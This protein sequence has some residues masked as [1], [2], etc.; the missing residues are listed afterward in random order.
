[1]VGGAGHG[2]L[3]AADIFR[4]LYR[5]Y[6]LSGQWLLPG[7]RHAEGDG[8]AAQLPA[9]EFRPQLLCDDVSGS[10]WIFRGHR[11]GGITRSP[12][13]S[14]FARILART[15]ESLLRKR[16]RHIGARTLGL[17]YAGG[18]CPRAVFECDFPSWTGRDWPSH[19]RAVLVTV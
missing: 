7:I 19:V 11:R 12:E 6:F 18:C 14:R 10:R 3:M 16:D 4:G 15:S 5:L 17:D 2:N 9:S 13:W 8:I 1:M